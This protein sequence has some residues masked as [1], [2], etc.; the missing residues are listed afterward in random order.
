MKNCGGG[1]RIAPLPSLRDTHPSKGWASLGAPLRGSCR[2]ATEGVLLRP[3]A[4]ILRCAQNERRCPPPYPSY[5]AG[6]ARSCRA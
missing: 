1:I 2:V 4:G 3:F 5:F 6:C